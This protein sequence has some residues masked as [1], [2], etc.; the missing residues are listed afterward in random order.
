M[1]ALADRYYVKTYRGEM[2][3]DSL[4]Q[5]LQQWLTAQTGGLLERQASGVKLTPGTGAALTSAIYYKAPWADAF[6]S[7]LTAPDVFHAPDGERQVDFMHRSGYGRVHAGERFSAVTVNLME[8]GQMRLLLPQAG[9]AAEA[10][11]TDDEALSFLCMRWDN[12]WEN[13]EDAMIHLAVPAF[14]VSGELQLADGLRSLGLTAAFDPAAADFSPLAG[15]GAQLVLS[16][17]AHAARVAADEEG[18][19]AAAYTV[20]MMDVSMMAPPEKEIDFVLDR[21]FVFEI[22]GGDGAPLFVGVVNQP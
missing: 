3:S 12:E 2:G 21:P 13:A 5:A 11:L 14:D 19:C 15:E 18:V 1:E 8:G 6:D 7:A 20:M 10:L 17:V 22:V 4:N 9:T 16:Q